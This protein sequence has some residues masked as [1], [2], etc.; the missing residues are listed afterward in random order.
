M[1]LYPFDDF[2]VK[3]DIFTIKTN[4]KQ[5]TEFSKWNES[6]SSTD[7]TTFIRRVATLYDQTQAN[8]KL[9]LMIMI[10]INSVAGDGSEYK[11]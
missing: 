1:T 4:K 5:H 8:N 10:I 9:P 11:N 6:A 2:V 7:H 3:N